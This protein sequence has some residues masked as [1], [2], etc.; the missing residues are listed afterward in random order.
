M[1]CFH[2][3]KKIQGGS[4]IHLEKISEKDEDDKD[5]LVNKHICGYSCYKRLS[6]N[7][8]LPRDL[9]YHIVNKED[10]NGLIRPVP[11]IKNKS[12]EY[13]TAKEIYDLS[14]IEKEKY[15]IEK[16][17]QVEFNSNITEIHDEIMEEDE[18]T[19]YLEYVSTDESIDDY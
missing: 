1:S 18:R 12:F 19:S 15:F 14:D 16:E 5:I 11:M 10:Y 9:W 3:Q 8:M 6:E 17:S 2:C 13:L 7:K 4:W